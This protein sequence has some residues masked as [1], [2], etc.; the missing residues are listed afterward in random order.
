M[1][2]ILTPVG[3]DVAKLTL[4]VRVLLPEPASGP[5][6]RFANQQDSLEQLQAWLLRL[7]YSRVHAC[8]EAGSHL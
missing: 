4:E 1:D 5:F 6:K 3:I 7:G 8:L 2:T